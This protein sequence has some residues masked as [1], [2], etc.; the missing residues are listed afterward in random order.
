MATP[1][2]VLLH[3]RR[4]DLGDEHHGMDTEKLLPVVNDVP[5]SCCGPMTFMLPG[6]IQIFVNNLNDFK[7]IA[8]RQTQKSFLMPDVLLRLVDFGVALGAKT[9]LRLSYAGDL[10]A[11]GP[12]AGSFF[13]ACHRLSLSETR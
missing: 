9:A 8:A 10:P 3:H 5:I 6:V 11:G 13:V 12:P 2:H 1:G 4:R 7:V